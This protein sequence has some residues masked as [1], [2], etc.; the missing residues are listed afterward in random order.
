MLA[1]T[2]IATTVAV[3]SAVVAVLALRHAKRSADAAEESVTEAKRSADAAEKSAGAAAITAEADRAE[4][5]RQRKPHLLVTV[6]QLAAHDGTAAIYRVTNEGPCD[7]DSVVVHLPILG[8]VE[9]RI[10][11]P[12]ATT[13]SDYGET[14]EVGPIVMGTYGRFTLSLGSGAALPKFRVKI[15]SRAGGEEWSE[16]VL[17]DHPRQPPPPR[18]SSARFS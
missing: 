13:G 14:A 2:I 15:V 4:D 3:V 10:H 18:G 1:L 5:H 7:L 11:H 17:L 8:E 16:V 12:V 6:D 9:G